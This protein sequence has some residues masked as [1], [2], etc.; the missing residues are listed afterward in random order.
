VQPIDVERRQRPVNRVRLALVVLALVVL[1]GCGGGGSSPTPGPGGTPGPTPGEQLTPGELR[2]LLVDTLGP[3]W[4]CDR[5]EYPVGRDEQRAALEA[6]EEMRAEGDVFAAVLDRLGFD[7]NGAFDDAEK[8]AVYRLW[9]VASSIPFEAVPSGDGYRFDYLAQPVGGAAEG[10]HTIGLIDV[11]GRITVETTMAAGEPMCP[12]CLVRGTLIE[13][14]D[15][16][17]PVEGLQVGDSVWTLDG[18]GRR[19]VGTVLAVGSTTAPPS[20]RVIR[21]ELADGRTLTASPGHPLADGRTLG[22]LR[23]GDLVDGSAV[24]SLTWLPYGGGRTFD[25]VVS[26]A[27]GLYFVDGIA[28]ASTIRPAAVAP[29]RS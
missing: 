1:A 2:L 11:T 18:S 26:G 9:K 8:L 27:T 16:P 10:V 17:V 20:H 15:G 3:R 25:L 21:L 5:D 19:A 29:A 23:L 28:I 4:Y 12:I 7:P 13:T 14:P 24:A 6:W 22:E